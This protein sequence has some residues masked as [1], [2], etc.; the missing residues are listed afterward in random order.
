MPITGIGIKLGFRTE[1]IGCMDWDDNIL[2]KL[3]DQIDFI[4][5]I[6]SVNSNTYNPKSI[7][8]ITC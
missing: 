5:R 3:N 2:L 8:I 7:N 1:Y 6:F 4:A